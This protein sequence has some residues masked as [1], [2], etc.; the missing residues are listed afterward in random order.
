MKME[1]GK[2]II[3]V[4]LVIASIVI[5]AG[6]YTHYGDETDERN[7]P[8]GVENITRIQSKGILE[9]AH[10]PAEVTSGIVFPSVPEKMII[11]HVDRDISEIELTRIAHNLGITDEL[12][13]SE[14]GWI[15]IGKGIYHISSYK[16]SINY[17]NR[18]D[19]PGFTPDYIDAHLPSDEEA[20]KIADEFLDRHDIRPENAVFYST[21]HDIGYFIS[22]REDVKLK[23][24][25]SINVWY[26]HWIGD[27]MI[28]TDKLYV[29]VG[30]HGE[31]RKMFRE[32]PAYEPY[33]EFPII[34]PEEAFGYLRDAAIV[35]PDGMKNPEKA[36]VT[37]V[38]LVYI[39][40][41]LTEDLDYFIPVYYFQGVVQGDG[42]SASFYQYI[43]ATP[44][45]AAEIT[46][47]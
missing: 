38:S 44:E 33:R 8:P 22:P 17:L 16:G 6:L 35:I 11:Y 2:F 36:T 19:L 40:H 1:H 21:N 24:S 31:V 9:S 27:Y 39:D 34:G 30:V 32:W 10:R 37:N 45:F 15:S 47:K 42:M 29:Q 25:E 12:S 26:K 18:T 46:G 3:G 5:V 28:L 41:T 7:L 23:N 20:R 13:R 14:S 4:I 43:P